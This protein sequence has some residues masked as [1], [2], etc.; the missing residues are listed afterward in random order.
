[1]H[2]I[3]IT[4]QQVAKPTNEKKLIGIMAEKYNWT[5]L[6]IIFFVFTPFALFS[7]KVSKFLTENGYCNYH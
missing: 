2:S 4:I 6:S 1:M 7:S 5:N 3:M